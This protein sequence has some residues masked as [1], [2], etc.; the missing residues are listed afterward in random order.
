MRSLYV[1]Y[2]VESGCWLAELVDEPAVHTFGRSFSSVRANLLDAAALWY[3]MDRDDL[4]LE[5]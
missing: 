5:P 2:R 1:A 3:E 4:I